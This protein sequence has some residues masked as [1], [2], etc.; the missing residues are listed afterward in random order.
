MIV[1][2]ITVLVPARDEERWITGCLEAIAAQDHPHHLLEVVVVVDAATSDETDQRAKEFL[3]DH[4][5]ARA[6]VVRN[7]GTTTPANLNAGLALARGDVVCR[8]DARSRVPP[9]YVRTCASILASR[10][11]VAVVGGSQVAV[12]AD[13]TSRSVGIARALNNR[14]GTGLARYRRG[15]A[16]G[17]ADTVYLG[18]FRTADLRAVGGWRRALPT[19]QDF[20]LNRRLS[21]RGI[22]WF[23]GSLE[24]GYV[25]RPH[26]AGLWRQYRRFGAA[27]VRYWRLSGDRPRPRQV[28]LL[29][30]V[31]AA[32]GLV[33]LA[34]VTGT[35]RRR[36]V[37]GAALV[38]L[39]AS[40]ESLGTRGPRGGLAARAWSAAALGTV[41]AGWLAGVW[42]AV[43]GVA[44]QAGGASTPGAT[45]DHRGSS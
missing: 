38:A 27:K 45:I 23:D 16:S 31:P 43:A 4:D 33:A 29:A 39:A 7:A 5:F 24:V 11:E 10:P 30:G 19:N 17:P 21:R 12:P 28:G 9:R 35:R 26:L 42:G 15:G 1:P 8:V 36:A 41:G 2:S 22:V 6:E 3:A 44:S 13:G 20:D 34:A 14:W 37:L 40:V 25:P 18:A 32:A